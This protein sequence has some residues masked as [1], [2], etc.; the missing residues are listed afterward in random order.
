MLSGINRQG[1]ITVHGFLLNRSKV[2]HRIQSFFLAGLMLVPAAHSASQPPPE[3]REHVILLHGMARTRRS[4]SALE[5]YLSLAGYAVFNTGYPS[6][7]ETVETIAAR[8]LDDMIAQCRARGAAR[9]HFVTHS[10]GGIVVRQYLQNHKLPSGS[11]VVMISPPNQGSE[12]ADALKD[13]I[14]YKWIYGPAGQVLG[15]APQSLPNSLKPVDA[16]IGVITG[17]RSL[18]PLF[19]RMI[20]G[21]DDGKVSVHRAKLAE[22]KDFLVVPASHAFIMKHPKVLKQVLWFLRTGGFQRPEE[23]AAL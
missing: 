7:T 23:D 4:M 18:N 10:L 12:L 3:I 21:D 8:H 1:V 14:F 9:I 13:F 20:P 19:S 6:T 17:N 5:H 16:E 11:R 15:T 22:M 2:R